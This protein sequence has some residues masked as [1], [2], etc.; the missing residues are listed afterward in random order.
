VSADL[1]RQQHA[2]WAFWLACGLALAAGIAPI[3]LAGTSGRISGVIF[4]LWLA[5]VCYGACALLQ[6]QGRTLATGIYFVAGLATVYGILAMSAVPLRLAVLGTCPS[7]P[8]RCPAG[9]EQPLTN[10]EN[11]GIGVAATLAIIAVLVGFFALVALYRRL[12]AGTVPKP[13]GRRILPFAAAAPSPPA[14]PPVRRIPP[15]TYPPAAETADESNPPSPV[16]STAE[17]PE[18]PAPEP[19]LELAAPAPELELPA[20]VETAQPSEP[21]AEPVATKTRP[22]KRTP[23]TP[24]ETPPPP[25]PVASST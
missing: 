20:H 19:Q 5:A 3:L 8:A 2:V 22:R 11:T 21:V 10:A 13:R 7:A 9:L 16:S 25:P 17:A 4:P 12:S 6:H 23:R 18:L 1:P 24:R 15:V 14:Q